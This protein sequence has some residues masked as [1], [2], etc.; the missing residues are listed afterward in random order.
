[1]GLGAEHQENVT[2]YSTYSL[3]E[4][5]YPKNSGLVEQGVDWAFIMYN[6]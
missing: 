6:I 5:H 2:K 1:M 3:A 4:M